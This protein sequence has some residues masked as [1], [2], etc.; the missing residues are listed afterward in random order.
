[1]FRKLFAKYES[2]WVGTPVRAEV[3][4]LEGRRLL[5]G[6]HLS[7][8]SG[9]VLEHANS[10]ATQVGV[11]TVQ[12]GAAPAAVQ[13]GLK[14][15]APS[16]ATIADTDTVSVRTLNS[17]TSLYSMKLAG[18]SGNSTCAW[19]WMRMDFRLETRR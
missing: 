12:F 18:S 17:T 4:G 6:S 1:M 2:K 3:E 9:V 13:D 5:S 14:A 11:T 19:R 15:I 7:A 8:A 10:T 16:G